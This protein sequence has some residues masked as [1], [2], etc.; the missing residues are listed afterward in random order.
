MRRVIAT[1]GRWSG[2][3]KIHLKS[4][5]KLPNRFRIV[6][7]RPPIPHS[8]ALWPPSVRGKPQRAIRRL[9]P[10]D[11]DPDRPEPIE[12]F[13]QTATYGWRKWRNFLD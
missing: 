9:P 13:P 4:G 6:L 11:L 10:P 7:R 2:T 5:P 12:I 8:I 3:L 1:V